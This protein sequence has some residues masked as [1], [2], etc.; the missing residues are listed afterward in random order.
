MQTPVA[1][2][3][4]NRPDTTEKVFEAISRAKP[5]KLFVIADG[6]RANQLGEAEKCAASRAIIDRVDWNCEVI[7]DY[8]DVNLG[9]GRR[10]AT[11]ISSMFERVEQAIILEDD[12]LP[13]LTFFRFCD[14]LLNKYRDD[15]R[16]MSISGFNGLGK[17][18]SN[19]QSYHF[20]FCPIPW[21]WASWSRAWRYFDYDIKAWAEPKIQ[22]KLKKFIANDFQ[23]REM[24]KNFD[25]A[26]RKEEGYDF[27]GYQWF[28]AVMANSG[29]TILPSVNLIS[30][31]GC[32]FNATHPKLARSADANTPIYSLQF[33]LQHNNSVKIDRR[34]DRK[35]MERKRGK[36]PLIKKVHK[37]MVHLIPKFGF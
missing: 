6:P 29:L 8:S 14:E 5:S 28:F 26:Y 18:K 31:I 13:D 19:K 32:N 35:Y 17:W 20:S 24:A 23:Y 12:C 30:N 4:F 16:I 9:C 34:F 10:I 3:I 7:K 1:L 37:K 22:Q 36:Q 27:W 15:E 25:K 2:I 33:P 21:G 11:G